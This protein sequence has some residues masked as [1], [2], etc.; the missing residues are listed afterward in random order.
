MEKVTA[1]I[2]Q[3]GEFFFEFTDVGGQRSERKKWMKIVVGMLCTS[4]YTC[5][6]TQIY[7][8]KYI[9]NI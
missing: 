6:Y 2:D 1:Q 8:D 3:F 9:M 4:I 7:M 5:K